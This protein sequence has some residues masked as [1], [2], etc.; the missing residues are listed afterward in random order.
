MTD[1][2]EATEEE[3]HNGSRQ[4]TAQ[5][6]TTKGKETNT[7]L[8]QKG[9]IPAV[10]YGAGEAPL[11]IQLDPTALQKSL[12]PVK[13]PQHA[14]HAD[15]GGQAGHDSGDGERRPAPC[16]ARSL[17]PCRPAAR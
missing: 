16:A 11:A 7:K 15:G 14:A 3:T 4:L 5:L 6:R 1:I 17:P 13:G 8:R 9:L 10:C 12:D 2:P